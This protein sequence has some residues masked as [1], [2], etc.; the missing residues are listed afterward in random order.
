[1]HLG[2]DEFALLLPGVDD[3][4]VLQALATEMRLLLTQPLELPEHQFFIDVS[5]GAARFPASATDPDAL[6]RAA[7]AA[8]HAAKQVPG[9]ALQLAEA[10]FAQGSGA[11]LEAE[12]ALRAGLKN[13]E[14]SLVYQPKV[15]A[16][17]GALVGFEALVRWDRPGHGRVSPLD[18]IPAAERTGLI[19]PLG[20]LILD[21]ACA[22]IAA[23]RAQ[24][25]H[26]VPV[27][28]NVSPVQ[29]LDAAFPDH[30]LQTLQ[31]HGVAPELLTLEM[32]E[33]AA[34]TSMAQAVEL[35]GRMR[36]RGV[37]FALDD[38][39]T[40]FSSLSMLRGLPLATLKIDRSLIDP[41]PAPEA[42][43]VVTAI[44]SLAAALKLEVVG[45]GVETE[46]HAQ[47]ALAAGCHTL[48]GYHFARPLE[49]DA[50]GQWLVRRAAA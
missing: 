8:M 20:S 49:P 18:F 40:G 31:R 3:D 15:D 11:S 19:V 48:Q 28:V 42:Q 16:A 33:S 46:T 32:T 36:E 12:Q 22:Q 44:C 2:E 41:L 45:E 4:H 35:I 29:L 6:Q 34:V 43:A 1:M 27:A 7:H 23:W 30:V 39:G 47:A 21:K 13:E 17:S 37:L 14:F 5:M 10:R 38:F 24:H 9:T 25:G 26:A 50:A